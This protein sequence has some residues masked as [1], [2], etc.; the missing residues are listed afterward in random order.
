MKNNFQN[1]SLSYHPFG[2]TMPGRIY[3]PPSNEKYRFG[4]NGKEKDDEGMGGGGSTYDYGF[5]IYNPQIAKFLSV[6]PLSSSYPWYT[7][8]QFAGNTPIQAID[9]D[10]LEEFDYRELPNY[11]G[12]GKTLVLIT[13][14]NDLLDLNGFKIKDGSGN[15]TDRFRYK[16]IDELMRNA[17]YK[18]K[19]KQGKKDKAGFS[20]DVPYDPSI[21]VYS[22]DKTGP[23]PV[24]EDGFQHNMQGVAFLMDADAETFKT[25]SV[26]IGQLQSSFMSYDISFDIN[27]ANFSNND[28]LN[29]QIDNIISSAG[30]SENITIIPNAAYAVGVTKDTEV[31]GDQTAGELLQKRGNAIKDAL[32]EKG[33]SADRII[34]GEGNINYGTTTTNFIID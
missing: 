8:Y 9:L 5:R 3:T 28:A 2:S 25:R 27:T 31:G 22:P 19:Y 14:G 26:S 33:V 21:A 15:E 20:M 6:D 4:F 24:L 12:S 11:Q 34:I 16:K 13:T 10:G 32:I 1:I 17:R 29:T 7:P 23:S 30:E 18:Q